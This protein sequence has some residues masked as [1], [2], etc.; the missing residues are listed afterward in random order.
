MCA[1]GVTTWFG[2]GTAGCVDG[3]AYE[4]SFHHPSSVAVLNGTTLL[5]S[6][7]HSHAVRTLDLSTHFVRTL[8]GSPTSDVFYYPQ[9]VLVDRTHPNRCF[10]A[11]YYHISRVENG[12]V[13]QVVGKADGVMCPLGLL[14]ADDGTELLWSE[15]TTGVKAV[16]LRDAIKPK[17]R[18]VLSAGNSPRCMCWKRPHGSH[19]PCV[20]AYITFLNGISSFNIKTGMLQRCCTFRSAPQRPPLT[21]P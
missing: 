11:S 5:V 14:L 10:V 8:C 1:D 15:P 9:N 7:Q 3:S 18:C 20:E 12:A 2:S 21:A 17:I 16:Q 6:D 4:A 19:T 13:T